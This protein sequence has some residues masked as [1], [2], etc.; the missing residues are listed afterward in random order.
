L[1]L[2]TFWAYAVILSCLAS[3]VDAAGIQLLD[4]DAA[5]SGVIWYPCKGEPKHLELGD[6]AVPEDFGLMGVKDCPVTGAR[7][8]L[9]I[10]SHGRGGWFGG[11]HDTAEALANAGFGCR[12]HQSP[13]RQRQ[14][15]LAAR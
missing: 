2:K 10:V 15:L 13:G 8:P 9:V 6:L 1:V 4:S 3:P 11:H 7:L 5:L 14:R 12:S